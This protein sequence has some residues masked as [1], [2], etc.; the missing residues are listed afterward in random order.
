MRSTRI[1]EHGWTE[2][3][4]ATQTLKL[5][6]I[7]DFTYLVSPYHRT[8]DWNTYFCVEPTKECRSKKLIDTNNT[9]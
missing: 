1:D 9:W 3:P 2:L 5:R 6:G 4:N 8:G 7:D